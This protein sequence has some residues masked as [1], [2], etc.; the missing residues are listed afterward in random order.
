M[1]DQCRP[2][3][4]CRLLIFLLEEAGF[5]ERAPSPVKVEGRTDLLTQLDG[6][7]KE[8]DNQVKVLLF[9]LEEGL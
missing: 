3:A 8:G 6:I 9:E 5:T 1:P 4:S 2:G 7:P